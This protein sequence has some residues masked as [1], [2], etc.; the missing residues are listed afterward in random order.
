RAESA[1]ARQVRR[2]LDHQ[3]PDGGGRL[4]P[5]RQTQ[6]CPH[7]LSRTRQPAV[8]S[9]RCP[10]ALS[11]LAVSC[12]ATAIILLTTGAADSPGDTPV[13]EAAAK[14]P[15]HNWELDLFA[16]YGQLAWPALDTTNTR[17]SNGN[18]A[19]AVSVAYR[20]PHFTHPFVDVS[21]VP[22]IWSGQDVYVPN[23]NGSVYSKSSSH[24]LGIILGPGFDISWF[25]VRGGVGL[26]A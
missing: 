9:G 19:F 2:L 16:G 23:T 5:G 15:L 20:S 12:L 18:V 3:R 14:A 11:G 4:P 26:Y 21:Y 1:V 10:S 17:W 25:R 22:F 13:Q 7:Q 8:G 24:A 6:R